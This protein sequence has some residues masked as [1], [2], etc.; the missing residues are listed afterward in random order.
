[1]TK[2]KKDTPAEG[3]SSLQ[4]IKAQ[5]L[6]KGDFVPSF[7]H[8][9]NSLVVPT[10]TCKNTIYYLAKDN[11]NEDLGIFFLIFNF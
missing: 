11:L 7:I 5:V 3:F 10:D 8:A 1:M 4:E 2:I 6:L 9:D